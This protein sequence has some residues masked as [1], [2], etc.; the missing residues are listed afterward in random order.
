M[1]CLHTN[2]V[3]FY[4]VILN[5]VEVTTQYGNY[6]EIPCWKKTYGEFTYVL[7]HL[8]KYS[9]WIHRPPSASIILH[10]RFEILLAIGYLV[11]S[12]HLW[13]LCGTIIGEQSTS[14]REKK[15]NHGNVLSQR[16]GV[17]QYTREAYGHKER[18]GHPQID[19]KLEETVSILLTFPFPFIL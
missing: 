17:L 6:K 2:G 15:I 3:K 5:F 4:S 12:R 16:G 1:T 19:W 8:T 14:K 18:K 13:L 11:K 7:R 10:L 9:W